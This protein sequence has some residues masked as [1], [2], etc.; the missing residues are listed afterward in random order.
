M[1]AIALEN[2]GPLLLALQRRDP[3]AAERLVARYGARAYRLAIGITRNAQD[4]EEV[5]QDALW[6]VIRKIDSFR[7]DA[8]FGSWLYRVVA[9]AAFAK[10]RRGAVRRHEIALDEVLPHF[11]EEGEHVAPIEDWSAAVEDPATQSGLRA[12]LAEAM[13]ELPPAYRAVVVLKDVEG[14]STADVADSL[15]ITLP[16]AKSRLHRARLFLRNRLSI[17]AGDD[18]ARRSPVPA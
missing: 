14:L 9:N 18:H 5:V 17:W 13:D 12:A 11:H 2:D 3:T 1:T 4:A 6:S 7:G 8:Q 10:L 16:N 15:G